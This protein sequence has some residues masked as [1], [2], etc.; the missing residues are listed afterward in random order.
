MVALLHVNDVSTMDLWGGGRVRPL[1]QNA[2]SIFA[3][4]DRLVLVQVLCIPGAFIGMLVLAIAAIAAHSRYLAIS[5]IVAS[6]ACVASSAITFHTI[7]VL[8]GA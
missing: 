5:A 3:Y 8:A 4:V 2:N 7:A 1:T 6:V